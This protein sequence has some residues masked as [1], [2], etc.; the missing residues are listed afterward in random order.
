L[1]APSSL[2]LFVLLLAFSYQY[3]VAFGYQSGHDPEDTGEYDPEAYGLALLRLIGNDFVALVIEPNAIYLREWDNK[4]LLGE[5]ASAQV[6][7]DEDAWYVI[8][9][10]YSGTNNTTLTVSRA[11]SGDPFE[12]LFSE[13]VSLAES[14]SQDIGF[15]V[16]VE[17][18]ATAVPF[19]PGGAGV[20]I[21]ESRVV[22][23]VQTADNV[24]THGLTQPL[25]HPWIKVTAKLC[26]LR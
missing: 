13:T 1:W 8:K 15:G 23:T 14:G 3:S 21:K 12:E 11:R 18:L 7:S 4:T 9:V 6:T 26:H 25:P 2:V 16:G 10:A 22:R 17:A 20:A 5:L 24:P 19:I